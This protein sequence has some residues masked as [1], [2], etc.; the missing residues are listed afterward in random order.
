M[1]SPYNEYR[2]A[3]IILSSKENRRWMVEVSYPEKFRCS[4]SKAGN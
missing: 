2:P 1:F 3:D 4:C